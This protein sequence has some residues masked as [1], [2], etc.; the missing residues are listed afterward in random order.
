MQLE[1]P[2]TPADIY[3]SGNEAQR[4]AAYNFLVKHYN[5]Q[6]LKNTIPAW[7]TSCK[8]PTYE[9]R[10][11]FSEELLKL[12]DLEEKDPQRAL[13]IATDALDDAEHRVFAAFIAA[14]WYIVQT[15]HHVTFSPSPR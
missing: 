6:L 5:A 8:P 3:I 4:I 7:N 12:S 13:E 11:A 9:E 2:L 15:H 14:G 1:C 10:R